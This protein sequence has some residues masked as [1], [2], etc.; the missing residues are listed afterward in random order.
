MVNAID[1]GRGHSGGQ[2][3]E[4]FK[5]AVVGIGCRFPGKVDSAAAFWDLLVSKGSGIR[6]IPTD[7]WSTDAFCDPD[8]DAIAK[9]YAKAGGFIDDIFDFDPNFFDLSP[10]E[11]LSMDPQQRLLLK[12][13]IEAI[14][15]SNNTIAAMRAARCG[16]FVGISNVDYAA[17]TRFRRTATDIF[18]GTGTAFSIAA[19]RISH[20]LNL[21]GPSFAV[22]TACSSALVAIDQACRNLRDGTCDAALAGGVNAL[23]EPSAFIAFCKAN[24][25][26]PTDT[27]SA[28]DKR[29][30]GFVRGEGA[31]LVLLKPLARAR[32][33]GDRIYAVIRATNVNQ[34]GYTSTLTAP[35]Y[36][37][38][39]AMLEQLSRRARV[40][41][42]QVK[43]VE[44]HG[45][46]TQVGDPIEARAIGRVFG[47]AAGNR[48][49]VMIGSVKPNVGHLEAAAGVCGFIKATL[50]A[51]HRLIPPT[52]NFKDPNPNIPMD[53][54][55]IEVPTEATALGEQEGAYI[56]V[57][58]FGFGGTNAGALLETVQ[59]SSETTAKSSG[60]AAEHS[61]EAGPKHGPVVIPVSA[62]TEGALKNAARDLSE[63][64]KPQHA[65]AAY[66]LDEIM[67][68]LG[69]YRDHHTER[70][71]VLA[72]DREDLA[73]KLDLLAAGELPAPTENSVVPPIVRGRAREGRKIAFTFAGQGGQWWGMGRQ[74]LTQDAIYRRTIE[75]FDDVFKSISGWSVVEAM[76]ADEQT[77]RIDD[78]EVTQAAIFANQIGLLAI[79][80]ARGVR[81]DVLIGHSFGEVAATYAAGSIS[82]NTAANLIHKRGLVRTEIGSLG[83]MAAVGLSH[84]QILPYLPADESV[85]IA[86][87]NGPTM[88]SLTGD[89][90]HMRDVLQR[91]SADFPTAFVRQLKMD[92]GWHGT[93]LDPGEAWFR[94]QLGNVA[95]RMPA[96]PVISTVTGRLETRF[97]NDYW[98]GNLRQPV[99]YQRAI[100]FA[101]ELGVDSFVELGPHRTLAALTTGI[102][103]NKGASALVVNSLHREQNDHEAM[104]FATATLHVNGVDVNWSSLTPSRAAKDMPLP[105]YPWENQ[106]LRLSSEESRH[107]LF[108]AEAHP[109]LGKRDQGP[110]PVWSS[111]LNLKAFRYIAD[112]AVQDGCLFPAAGYVEILAAAATS[113]YGKG[114]VELE[115][116]RFH[117]ALSIG[118][119]DE[120]ML[121]TELDPDRALVRIFGMRRGNDTEWRLCA[122]G[123][124]RRRDLTISAPPLG[125]KN[126]AAA[127]DLDHATF[128]ELANRHGLNYERAFKGVNSIWLRD[129]VSIMAQVSAHKSLRASAGKYIVHPA[130]LDSCLQVPIALSDLKAGVWVP[131]EPLRPR[132]EVASRLRLK[133]PVGIRRVVITEA[134]PQALLVLYE[135]S[136]YGGAYTICDDT[137]RPIVRI[138]GLETRQLG[139]A[140]RSDFDATAP[141]VYVE[142]FYPVEQEPARNPEREPQDQRWL[143]IGPDSPVLGGLTAELSRHDVAVEHFT[144]H[145]G[146][147]A[148]AGE[149]AA[150]LE[151]GQYTGIVY[152][153]GLAPKAGSDAAVTDV[154]VADIERDVLG[155]IELGKALDRSREAA[156]RPIV[157]VLTSGARSIENSDSMSFTG[158]Q[159][160]PL[161]GLARSLA[162]ECPEFVVRQIDADERSLADPATIAAWLLDE[163]SE[164]ELALRAGRAW[165]P[166][167]ERRTM[168]NLPR[169]HR[170]RDRKTDFGNFVVTMS[171]PGLVENIVLREAETPSPGPN[172]VV[173]EVAAVGLNFRDVLAA[174][175]MLPGEVEGAEAA[176]RN[177]GLEFGG[178]VH[179]V[180][181][182]VTGLAIGD[183]VMGMGSGLLR[184]FA[185]MPAQA[186]MRIPA[187]ISMVEA[188]S[189]PAGFA[190]AI[191]SLE[192]VARLQAGEKVLIHLGTGGVGLAAIQV[193]KH[194]GAEIL[195]TAG[196]DIKREHLRK[197]GV[198]HVMDSRSLTFADEV[199]V[200]TGG[201]GVD[202][203]LN[204]LAGLA[205]DKGIACLAPFGRF[206]EIGKRDLFADKPIG[207]KSLYFNNSFAVVDLSTLPK[208]RPEEMRRLFDVLTARFADGTYRPNPVTLFPVAK[209]ADA[210]RTMAKAQHIGKVV[211]DLA[212]PEIAIED[213]LES[214]MRFNGEATYVVTGGLR[215]FGV[216]VADWL[217][218]N[219]AGRV[220]LVSRRT[221]LEDE[222]A[223]SIEQMKA[224][225]TDVVIASLDIT[226]AN[227]VAGLIA[228]HARSDMPLRG[229][230]HGAAVIEDGFINQLDPDK[231]RRV[232][233][234]KV[235]G[236]LNLH[237]ALAANG[238]ELDFFVSFSSLAQMIGSAGQG[239]YTAANAFLDA[240]STYRKQKGLPG[241]AVDWGAL[242]DSGFVARN[243]AMI[244]Y[245]D[246]VG[247]KMV[248][249]ADAFA[250]LGQL[251]RADLPSAAFA[252][253]NWQRV[254][255]VVRRERKLPRLSIVLAKASGNDPRV[256]ATL[257]QSARDTWDDILTTAITAEV[258]RVLKVDAAAI[259]EDRLLTELGLDSLSSFELK[260][261]IE[262]MLDFSI[263][264]G[265]FL[266]AP[267]IRDLARVA[268]ECFDNM[269]VATERAAANA[270]SEGGTS[271]GQ[272]E[273]GGFRP[274]GR[275]LDALRLAQ[276]P[277]TSDSARDSLLL[278]YSELIPQL[279]D[280]D[281]LEEA[282]QRLSAKQDAL[283][284]AIA[285][286]SRGESEIVFAEGPNVQRLEP[287][288]EL[289]D[290]D[291]GFGPLWSF[292]FAHVGSDT[293]IS[294]RSH[295][296]A[297]DVWS[298]PTAITRLLA[299]YGN[300]AGGADTNFRL[301]AA[302]LE[303]R[304]DSDATA[305]HLAVWSEMLSD[306]PPALN[307]A[308][309]SFALAPVGCGH[310]RGNPASIESKVELAELPASELREREAT[311]LLAFARAMT[312]DAGRGS[313]V[314]C[315]H[316]I[317]RQDCGP[318]ELLGPVADRLPL[319]L[320]KLDGEFTES[321]DRVGRTL[322]CALQHRAFDAAAAE[323]RLGTLLR[324]RGAVPTQIGFAYVDAS[325][326]LRNEAV[327]RDAA[328]NYL[329]GDLE[330]LLLDHRDYVECV[331]AYD[332]N[333]VGREWVL[334]IAAR[335]AQELRALAHSASSKVE[336]NKAALAPASDGVQ[337]RAPKP[338]TL[339]RRTPPK[340]SGRVVALT[341]AA[342]TAPHSSKF[343]NIMPVS[344]QQLGVLEFFEGGHI[345][346]PFNQSRIRRRALSLRPGLDV[347]R[348]RRAIET[349][350]GRHE[351]LRMRF[352]HERNQWGVVVEPPRGDIFVAEDI[353]TVD[354]ATLNRLI[355]DHL[356]QTIDPVVGPLLQ[357]R[358]LR[359]GEHGDVLLLRGHHLVVDDWS[360][361]IVL[362]EM[363]Q[364]YSGI[365][366]EAPSRMTHERYLREFAGHGNHE[367]IAER[368][369]YFRSLLI[370]GLE[371]PTIGRAKKGLSQAAVRI[372]AHPGG[373]TTVK[374]TRE[375]RRQMLG[376]ARR[377]GVSDAA[378]FLASYA[379]TIGRI[380][381]VDA[382]QFTVP[383][384]NRGHS[385]L[386]GYVG[387]VAA[388]MPVC[389]LTPDG[390]DVKLRS[391]ELHAQISTSARHLPVDF[392]AL[393]L[394]GPSRQEQVAAYAR[395]QQFV[396]GVVMPDHLLKV[397]PE[398][399]VF[400]GIVG[401]PADFGVT[402]VAPVALPSPLVVNELDLRIYDTGSEFRYVATYDQVAF[403]GVEI[404]EI[405]RETF[406]RAAGHDISEQD[407]QTAESLALP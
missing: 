140:Q 357:I 173:V 321:L 288:E 176:W 258:A 105:K 166:R 108:V 291:P 404:V 333:A 218:A 183:R 282:L 349:V 97:D 131:G 21:N 318:A 172:E 2:G 249:N 399:S 295:A 188:G 186:V 149:F 187:N 293:R 66:P 314:I 16:V 398:A 230:V 391:R 278:R 135:G 400:S 133:L 63:A 294:V 1:A 247:M 212:Q 51:H 326:E 279:L 13:A 87:F 320:D 296:A 237:H 222:V 158:L 219:G 31:G 98:W 9:G 17:L 340:V 152:A 151:G 385:D 252:A 334:S 20:R 179:A 113:H 121:R 330:L 136:E 181:K 127:P 362:D 196:S 315:R 37:A 67:V 123:Y 268:A 71:A 350:V 301:F 306:V 271:G 26:S 204:S 389:C 215:G 164:T 229:V 277:M 386:L 246:S 360:L 115:H 5:I 339:A 79:W 382:V 355:A 327:L 163:G 260:N 388:M 233:K 122:E 41:P 316:D 310:N 256:R 18:A 303:L 365:P 223:A 378:L 27:I 145:P 251:A 401:E 380:G 292:G 375:S 346:E 168:S 81:P 114:P 305:N 65:L 86:A 245:L 117:E 366:L 107:A 23:L 273:Q 103:Q 64:L 155:L 43:Y 68:A 213:D 369:S 276:L 368:E 193:A 128:Y 280:F 15:D 125:P 120:I 34:D 275:Q 159:Q 312:A 372:D 347:N 287:H 61:A 313:I 100:E 396:G 118:A 6:P 30:N 153:W 144:Q 371:L 214:A 150:R 91:I 328:E 141:S 42:K 38:Q 358:L 403:S 54:L 7:R 154:V 298:M 364:A 348:L 102:V 336:S 323:Q 210:Y 299:E 130:V 167:I 124:V 367:V 148:G 29:A 190:T 338:S 44:A 342:L 93:Q 76:L 95:C 129:D 265:K 78:A 344:M 311:V 341:A 60:E 289:A 208:E 377:F 14:E 49:R 201:R 359:M 227:A 217:S 228:Q 331:W 83:A 393:D 40:A 397:V 126:F 374:I 55:N 264:V 62:A 198:T 361:A 99:S 174:T 119:D 139:T 146:N 72:Y 171:Q 242:G 238:A 248:S 337:I 309:R 406:E 4:V 111:E 304:D 19:N 185:K 96:I 270:T 53:A 84:E 36:E 232:I 261:R 332:S 182:D 266:Q 236:A 300:A 231:V 161:C 69:N 116:I 250:A 395:L 285:T 302:N 207:L 274:L 10:R 50:M 259:P 343:A 175:G 335:F 82:L 354:L 394:T 189:I 345:H 284:L 192:W 70:A 376:R 383:A 39:V 254:E 32:A 329:G 165:A 281:R 143:L 211:I 267:T 162:T 286:N 353:G 390:G 80:N 178:V 253:V 290:V 225:G 191:Y 197:L 77:T 106:T 57:N 255:R 387:S 104:A 351:S 257:M 240:F 317:S 194:L 28:F 243:A 319:V 269:L 325:S 235:A 48:A 263:P 170:I 109:L 283:R 195:A 216:S 324:N 200:A 8:H 392:A 138:E 322:A 35:S 33:D 373:E 137:G 101:L 205:I 199:M 221:T 92:F 90:E 379:M 94:T 132:E 22:D 202:V 220:V 75:E 224:R 381:D 307:F 180:G 234:P 85:A 262:G 73:G 52:L 3:D 74:L 89:A 169:R 226:D 184:G 352:V 297:A 241:L 46:G 112:H 239:N 160:A 157:W 405:V 45:T 147:D 244:S 142:N 134:F 56:V 206:I 402:K 11:A 25:L 384:A 110:L 88:H 58:S 407:R 12:V 47:H 156:Q 59:R 272:D 177:M 370:P 363:F 209:T 24:M 356:T 203:V 308:Q